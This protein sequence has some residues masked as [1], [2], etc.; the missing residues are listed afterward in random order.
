MRTKIDLSL[1]ITYIVQF[2]HLLQAFSKSLNNGKN[3]KF[4]AF[5][6]ELKYHILRY[7]SSLGLSIFLIYRNGV[8]NINTTE[9]ISI[10]KLRKEFIFR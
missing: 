4:V 6:N 1:Q 3:L 9:N 5:S 2:S 8:K 7:P 10:T